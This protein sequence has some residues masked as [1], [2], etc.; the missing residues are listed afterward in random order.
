MTQ[1][2]TENLSP[3]E[4][5]AIKAASASHPKG[6]YVLFFAELWERFSYYG[7]RALLILYMTKE[8]LFGDEKAYGIY[9]AYGALVYGAPL[10]GGYLADRYLGNRRAIYLGGFIIALGHFTLALPI[11]SALYY[12][13]AFIIVGT[14]FF[15]ANVASLVGQLYEKGDPRRDSGFTLFYM[16]IN[17]GGFLA[18]LACG[19]V[20]ET[21]GWHYGFALAGFGMLL[22][23]LVLFWGRDIIKDVGF[24]PIG[25]KLDKPVFLGLSLFKITIIL[26]ILAAPLVALMVDHNHVL[27]HF[28]TIFGVGTLAMILY[29]IYVSEKEERKCLLTILVMLPFY[30]IFWACFEQAGGSM[31]LFAER[32]VDKML[33][34]WELKTSWFQSLNPFFIVTCA[35]LFTLLW[36]Y[37]TKKRGRD[38]LTSTK[39]ALGLA[40]AGLGFGCLLIAIKTSTPEGYTAMIWLVLAYLLHSTG[41]LCISPVGLSMVSKLSPARFASFMMGSVYLCI[42][43]GHYIAAF[44]ARFFC[45]CSEK[46]ITTDK[47]ASLDVFYRIY[48]TLFYFPLGAAVLALIIGY[49]T[50]GIFRRHP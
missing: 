6:L 27:K 43:F 26:G 23:I 5:K 34:G 7:M 2:L 41:E 28:V 35:P 9:G 37:I 10:V 38:L 30:M 49:F 19:F 24:S 46:D 40:Q 33:F 32:N 22:G 36:D 42:S 14:G 8:L 48:E 21:F 17:L 31:N 16:G 20:G 29:F 39:F 13:I 47:I 18:P 4:K 50:K 11:Q 25:K 45:E 3:I 44:I 1:T 15:K 12:G